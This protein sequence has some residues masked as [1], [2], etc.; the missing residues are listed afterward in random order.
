MTIPDYAASLVIVDPVAGAFEAL[1][2]N[3]YSTDAPSPSP[4]RNYWSWYLLGAFHQKEFLPDRVIFYGTN[5]WAGT[6]SVSYVAIVNAEG[7]F[8]LPPALAYDGFQ[9]E[10][11]GLSAGGRFTTRDMADRRL[12]EETPVATPT[13]TPSGGRGNNG[14][15]ENWPETIV[16]SDTL[17]GI[18]DNIGSWFRKHS[19]KRGLTIQGPQCLPWKDRKLNLDLLNSQQSNFNDD[20]QVVMQDDVKANARDTDSYGNTVGDGLQDEQ[21]LGL[22]ISIPLAVIVVAAIAVGIYFFV[23]RRKRT[24]LAE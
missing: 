9:P 15:R 7:E 13:P 3:I 19:L 22:A 21:I 20:G 23:A 24:P 12:I 4:R 1:D 10:L 8:V 16:N 6:H 2:E 5:I 11:M 14:R 17:D 18:L